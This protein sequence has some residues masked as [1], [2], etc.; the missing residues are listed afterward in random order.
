VSAYN[1]AVSFTPSIGAFAADSIIFQNAFT[2][3]TGTIMAEPAI[4]SGTLLLH[5]HYVQPFRLVNNLEKLIQADGYQAFVT[6]D[7]ILAQLL[8]PAPDTVRLDANVTVDRG[9]DLC[10]TLNEAEVK[11]DA[12]SERSRPIFLYTQP[13]NVHVL[14]LRERRGQ[15]PITRDYAPFASDYAS[16]L[17]RVD[18][19]FGGF[20]EYLKA[21]GLYDNSIIVLTADHGDAL[22]EQGEWG[23]GRIV[24]AETLRVPLIVHLPGRMRNWSYDTS[25]IAFNVDITPTLYYLLG[26]RPIIDQT[27]LGRPLFTVS[28]SEFGQYRQQSFLVGASYSPAFGVLYDNGNQLFVEDEAQHFERF[29]DLAADPQAKHDVL[30]RERRR[31]GEQDV[32]RELEAIAALFEYHYKPKTFLDWFLQ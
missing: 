31:R 10:A 13:E 21:R 28:A 4:W 32:R 22:G 19:C 12:R 26:H 25:Q 27:E 30:N 23:H 17:E 8:S 7:Q 29:F 16:E 6:I 14:G 5:K 11:I 9:L 20:V 24:T 3:Y 18:G 1:P 15:H 2:R